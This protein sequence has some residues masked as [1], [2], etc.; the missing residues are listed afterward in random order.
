MWIDGRLITTLFFVVVIHVFFWK[1]WVFLLFLILKNDID[2]DDDI[3]FEIILRCDR[4]VFMQNKMIFFFVCWFLSTYY[5]IH[6]IHR[7]ISYLSQIHSFKYI[8]LIFYSRYYQFP[9][10]FIY[11]SFYLLIVI[12]FLIHSHIHQILHLCFDLSRHHYFLSY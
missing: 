6:H 12:Q 9:F 1:K 8:G 11:P 7:I 3:D 2:F 4:R 5:V 10:Q